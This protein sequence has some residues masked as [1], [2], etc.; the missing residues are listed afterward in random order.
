MRRRE[1]KPN[2]STVPQAMMS[3]N[4][5][6]GVNQD[7]TFSCAGEG[8]SWGSHRAKSIRPKATAIHFAAKANAF[9]NVCSFR[10]RIAKG[11]NE[12]HRKKKGI[13][14]TKKESS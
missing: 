10:V 4:G 14:F 7:L 11:A 8:N 5:Q 2:K 1:K 9:F 3:P 13:V 12:R 6:D